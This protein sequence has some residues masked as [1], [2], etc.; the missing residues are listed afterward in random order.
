MKKK[1]R[2]VFSKKEKI[3]M[4][5]LGILAFILILGIT[6][7][8]TKIKNVNN[9]VAN[10]GDLNRE[11][12]TVKDVVEYLEST[13]ISMEE[14]KTD[15]YELDIYVNFKYD[16]YEGNISK[17]QYFKNFYEKIAVVTKFK[18]F[19]IIDSSK[20]ITIEVKCSSTGISEVKINGDVN[21]YKNQDSKR[22][23]ANELKV[24]TLE[25]SVNSQVLQ[26]LINAKWRASAVNLGTKESTYEKYDV[27]FDEGYEIRNI[28][29]KVF[30]IVFT[31][32]YKDKVVEGYKVGDSLEKIE[33]DLGT[34]YKD[35][36]MI[37]YKTKNFYIIFSADQISVY[38]NYQYD[39]TEFEDLVKEYNDKKD[40][41]DFM[42]K[43]T[44]IWPD[45][46][47]YD[48]DTSYVNITYTLKGVK[49][50][51]SSTKKDGIQ[52]FEN[53]KGSL[54]E[55]KDTYTDL[56]YKLDKNLMFNNETLRK[57]NRMYDN[58][59]AESDPIH[60]SNKFY[61]FYTLSNQ[62]YKN[63]KIMSIDKEHPNNEFDDTLEITSYV[64]AD[65]S[66][67][68]YGVS[69]D[70]IYIYDAENRTT[71]KILSGKDTYKITN[72]NRETEI[73]EYDDVKAKINF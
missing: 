43:L 25:L 17:E 1:K 56:Y 46:D 41:N 60:Y 47:G 49:I 51:F 22:S 44:D 48:Y 50:S 29:G 55:T 71:E 61:V 67:M 63:I 32:K 6:L 24:E 59:G 52:I 57:M 72:Y 7:M 16:L 65:D 14:S 5:S 10:N 58:T 27:Y 73:I 23:Q 8:P 34:S 2:K 11:L 12:T 19:R 3:V 53:Y 28:Q 18:S 39:Y 9:Q 42:D 20:D 21:Y 40:I 64:W 13:F 68:I 54:K 31:N 36:G 35:S 66:H 37:G 26:D 15:G 30:N 33:G 45:Y 62:K 4:I 70:G 69:G 38:P